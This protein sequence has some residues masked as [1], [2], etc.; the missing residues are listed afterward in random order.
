MR[1]SLGHEGREQRDGNERKARSG[2]VAANLQHVRQ[3]ARVNEATAVLAANTRL[4]SR[5][6]HDD[7]GLVACRDELA[8][9]QAGCEGRLPVA[10]G[11]PR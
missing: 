7:V 1:N 2:A 3:R 11:R 5:R 6:R 8:Q 10:P 4:V 9:R